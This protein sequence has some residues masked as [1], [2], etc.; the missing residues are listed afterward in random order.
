MGPDSGG[1]LGP[2]VGLHATIERAARDSYSRLLA[3]V[4]ARSRDVAAAE[5]AL[6][7]AFRASLEA[8]PRSAF[9]TSPRP[10]C[11]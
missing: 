7:D 3:F 2:D 9:P 1:E 5:D 4:A 8:W 6:A 10:G 11:S